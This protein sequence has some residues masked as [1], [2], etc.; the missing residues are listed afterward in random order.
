M[1]QHKDLT[2]A[3]LHEPKGVAAAS[4]NQLYHANGSGSGTWK[5]IPLAALDTSS[6]QNPNTV[7]INATLDDVSTGSSI[8]IP[9][10]D[11]CTFESAVFHLGGAITGA[12]SVLTLTRNDGASVGSTVTIAFTGSAE[13]TAFTFTA[14]TNKTITAPGYIK[15]ATDGGSTGTVPLYCR[16]KFLRVP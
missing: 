16:L 1:P 7:Y 5:K 4:S 14:T 6:L 13:G 3:D 9:A 10:P 12:D 11:G 8:L 2:G 15:I